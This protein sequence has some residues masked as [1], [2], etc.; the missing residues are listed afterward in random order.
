MNQLRKLR[1]L[2]GY[3]LLAEDGI[4]GTLVKV[5]FD[6]QDWAVRYFVVRMG[7]WVLGREVLVA[8]TTV[9]ETVPD[10]RCLDV[11][12]SCRQI[13]SAPSAD[14]HPPV[15]SHYE[16]QYERFV[17]SP[18]YRVATPD[19]GLLR[20][21]EAAPQHLEPP[22]KP[23]DPHLH[24]STEL[25]GYHI[26]ARDGDIGHVEDFILEE[27][28]WKIRFL[29]VATRKWLPGKHVLIAPMWILGVDWGFRHVT[30]DLSRE[31]IR[32]APP[33]DRSRAISFADQAALDAHYGERSGDS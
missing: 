7:N 28:D 18:P 13:E 21:R 16:Q 31:A 24:D 14:T 17:S 1:E 6:D 25:T 32:T 4:V 33:Y 19:W 9:R 22:E 27:P 15:S 29:E 20:P 2:T 5:Y 26:H 3:S 23:A 30:V 8:P 10:A 11:A 12:L